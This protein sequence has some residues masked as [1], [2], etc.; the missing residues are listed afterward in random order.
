MNKRNSR[1]KTMVY[2][3]EVGDLVEEQVF[4]GSF[5]NVVYHFYDTTLGKLLYNMIF[6]K[7]W[8]S[9]LYTL[10]MYSPRSKRLIKAFVTDY[11]LNLDEVEKPLDSY[12]TM[13]EFFIRK[14]KPTARPIDPSP[15]LLISPADSRLL[16]YHIDHNLVL[17][18]K[19]K[20][21]SIVKLL[22]DA[23][24]AASFFNGTC[25]VFR[26]APIDYHRFCYIDHGHQSPVRAIN[27][28]LHSVSPIALHRLIPVFRENYRELCVL[29]TNNFGEVIHLDVGAIT[30]G[31]ITQH[32]ME[33]GPMTKGQE[34]GYFQFGGSTI[35]L[36]FKAGTVCFDE[37]IRGHSNKGIEVLVK[38]GQ[39]IGKKRT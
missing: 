29:D 17:P 27:G 25:A 37:V 33:A 36:L 14:L 38:Y 1:S 10:R 19:G 3:P 34:K 28:D 24:L 23:D 5:L 2:D 9:S 32:Q 26:L 6:K 39:A 35:V 7:K 12:E 20:S 4:G 16:I 18:V 11:D 8:F 30:V 15:E 31:R 21:F 13:N 22:N